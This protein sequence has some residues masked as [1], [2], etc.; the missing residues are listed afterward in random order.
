MR[1]AMVV[2]DGEGDIT[3]KEF[4]VE[5]DK[6]TPIIVQNLMKKDLNVD[7]D[8]EDNEFSLD[9]EDVTFAKGK[10]AAWVDRDDEGFVFVVLD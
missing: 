2:Q 4:T 6:L 1:V 5:G 10:K 7:E 8:D 9:A 3:H